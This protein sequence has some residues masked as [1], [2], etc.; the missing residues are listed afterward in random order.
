MAEISR[1][2]LLSR[3]AVLAGLALGAGFGFTKHVRH[4]V[5]LPPPPP[6]AALADALGRQQ[7]LLAGYDSMGRH[8]G[9]PAVPSLRSDVAAHG[10]ALRALLERYPGWRIARTHP[11]GSSAPTASA[12][13]TGAAG[14]S[15]SAGSTD[16]AAA[17]A[18]GSAT[19]G[20]TTLVQLAAATAADARALTNAALAWPASEQ[21]AVEVVATL[22]SIAA[23]LASHAQVLA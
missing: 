1:R 18:T 4:K 3:T 6:P 9:W 23:C 21:H 19:S 12:G 17:S 8:Y 15:G 7:R 5:A 13:P 2:T 16:S 22:A 20:R 14:T 10:D 11:A